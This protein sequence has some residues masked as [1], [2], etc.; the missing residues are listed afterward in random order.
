MKSDS[1]H[2]NVTQNKHNLYKM[3]PVEQKLSAVVAVVKLF[4]S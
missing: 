1:D 3:L 2:A 4:A